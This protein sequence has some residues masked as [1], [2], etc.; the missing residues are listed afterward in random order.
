ME[1]ASKGD[2][3]VDRC[4]YCRLM[5]D[6]RF[7]LHPGALNLY[8]TNEKLKAMADLDNVYGKCRE[9]LKENI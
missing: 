1:E 5:Y 3:G 9:G 7:K 4:E 2:V 6:G 8:Y